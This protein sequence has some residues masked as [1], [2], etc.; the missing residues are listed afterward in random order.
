MN[1]KKIAAVFLVPAFIFFSPSHAAAAET[2]KIRATIIVASNQ[3][4]SP[5]ALETINTG[6]REQLAQLFSY[7]SY[8]QKGESPQTLEQNKRQ[9]I[10]LPDGYKLIL[11]LQTVSPTRVQVR[12][13][14]RKDN[15]QFMDTVVSILKPGTVFLGGPPVKDGTLI[16][17]LETIF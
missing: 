10:D 14:V 1:L 7:H 9:V 15:L 17:V 5:A 11:L 16:I 8:E 3:Q 6:Y 12:A 2:A 4:Q 13:V